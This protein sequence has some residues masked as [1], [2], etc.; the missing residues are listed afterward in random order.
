MTIIDREES[1]LKAA[2]KASVIV[3]VQINHQN[4]HTQSNENRT[5]LF[6]FFNFQNDKTKKGLSTKAHK[7]CSKNT[8]FIAG[9]S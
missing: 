2:K 6:I 8:I 7:K 4:K 9:N 1:H 3:R 5:F